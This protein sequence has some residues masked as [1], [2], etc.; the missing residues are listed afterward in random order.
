LE[1]GPVVVSGSP[2]QE[3]P[4]KATV[5]SAM[6]VVPYLLVLVALF[7][8]DLTVAER[9]IA[10]RLLFQ[11]LDVFRCPTIFDVF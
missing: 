11:V 7:V 4:I 6:S 5:L 3:I 2:V 8:L 10:I 9:A 1:E